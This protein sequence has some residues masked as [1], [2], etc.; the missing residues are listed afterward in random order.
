MHIQPMICGMETKHY[1]PRSGADPVNPILGFWVMGYGLWVFG[2]G[3][4]GLSDFG[5]WV[6]GYR[7]WAIGILGY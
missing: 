2:F 6:I 1:C 7:L 4:F 5:F 3:I